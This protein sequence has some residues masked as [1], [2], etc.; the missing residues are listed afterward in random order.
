MRRIGICVDLTPN[1][2]RQVVIGVQRYISRY[3]DW[4]LQIADL[5]TEVARG[6]AGFDGWIVENDARQQATIAGITVPLVVVGGHQRQAR[7]PLVDVDHEAIGGL[8]AT[9]LAG[10]GLRQFACATRPGEQWAERRLA[11]FTERLQRD[12]S[13]P[14]I[15]TID[16]RGDA[17]G[18]IAE[19]P[20]PL[21]LFV[22]NDL[23]ARAIVNDCLYRGIRVPADVAVV[24][25]D[26]DELQCN[27][28]SPVL[29]SVSVPFQEVG[30]SAAAILDGLLQRRRPPMVTTI[31]PVGV[32]ERASSRIDLLVDQ[33]IREALAFIHACAC[34]GIGPAAVAKHVGLSL[35]SLEQRFV[36]ALRMTPTEALL[37]RR[38]DEA[39]RLLRETSEPIGAIAK[40]CGFASFPHFSASFRARFH[41]P[42]RAVR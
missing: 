9:H 8:A 10:L 42:P 21:G 15:H 16:M 1:F 17:L 29:S 33:Q 31:A 32:V 22:I 5:A 38:L 11:G 30:E 19:L 39:H 4:Q 24:G 28:C 6:A 41:R 20:Q 7:W 14:G 25:C 36:G 2:G 37:R 34:R 27:L 35:R 23:F 3:P 40:R 18:A 26:D 12:P 13:C